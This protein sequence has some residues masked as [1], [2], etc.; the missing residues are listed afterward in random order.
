MTLTIDTR[1][2]LTHLLADSEELRRSTKERLIQLKKVGGIVPTIVL[3]EVYNFVCQ[4]VGKDVAEMR[5]KS[6]LGEEFRIV[7]LNTSIAINSAR[8]KYK[9]R[10]LPTADAIIAA[11]SIELKST[12]IISDDPHFEQIKEVKTEWI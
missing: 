8:L 1:F 7:E 12:R 10:G 4:H 6:I 5:V 2:F 11:T 3:H 9:Y